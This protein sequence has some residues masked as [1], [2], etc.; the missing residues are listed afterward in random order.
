EQ[1]QQFKHE[2]EQVEKTCAEH[3]AEMERF[4]QAKAVAEDHDEGLR[5]RMTKLEAREDELREVQH[6]LETRQEQY[7]TQEAALDEQRQQF[8]HEQ[9]QQ[10]EE[11]PT[12]AN[13]GESPETAKLRNELEQMNATLAQRKL[14]IS[15]AA[16]T[17]A[18]LEGHLAA[19]NAQFANSEPATDEHATV[20]EEP[21]SQSS[22]TAQVEQGSEKPEKKVVKLPPAERA[23]RKLE[24]PA[25]KAPAPAQPKQSTTPIPQE[26]TTGEESANVVGEPETQP[27]TEPA[28][29]PDEELLKS[30]DAETQSKIKVLR[31][32][33][34]GGKSVA[35]LLEQVGGGAQN[36]ATGKG[37][38]KRRWFGR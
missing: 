7:A 33:G 17:L 5:E 31:R 8:K 32:L 30:L 23:P 35:E 22:R 9:E 13:S 24:P 29:D 14:E 38:K 16:D 37:P 2:Q 25:V 36:E 18:E 3:V 15:E 27:E 21:E 4:E 1:R 19:E 6:R 11:T 28:I 34:G 20:P 10:Q 26:M 12:N